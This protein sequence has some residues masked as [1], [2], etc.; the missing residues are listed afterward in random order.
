MGWRHG[1]PLYV[2]PEGAVSWPLAP[3]LRRPSN[4]RVFLNAAGCNLAFVTCR[5]VTHS[6]FKARV[7]KIIEQ[8]C[9]LLERLAK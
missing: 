6:I 9:E 2:D 1:R 8:D 4:E 7:R 5:I 3:P